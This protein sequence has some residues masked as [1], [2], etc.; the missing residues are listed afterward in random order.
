MTIPFDIKQI[1]T[2]F[3]ALQH[4]D[5]APRAVY[6]D[7]AA[8]A[9]KPAIVIDTLSHYYRGYNANVHRGSHSLTANATLA[10]EQARTTV[11]QFIGAA[12]HKEIIWT[13]GATEALNLIA[14]TYA[15]T[16]FKLALKSLKFQCTV[17]APWILMLINV[18]YPLKQKLSQ[19]PISLMLPVLV[20]Q[21]NQ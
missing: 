12:S 17:I 3:P 8:T 10:F 16:H 7:S 18:Y 21:S 13:R 20:I 14:Q 2:Q 19:L 1:Q 4:S 9:Q 6:L 15:R 5:V 11:Q